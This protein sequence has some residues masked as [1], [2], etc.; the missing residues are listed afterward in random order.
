MSLHLESFLKNVNWHVN[1][2]DSWDGTLIKV[3]INPFQHLCQ[4]KI[5]QTMMRDKK[6]W[7]P[8]G[9]LTKFLHSFSAVI[10]LFLRQ[11]KQLPVIQEKISLVSWFELNSCSGNIVP[12]FFHLAIV[13]SFYGFHS[14]N[15]YKIGLL[16]IPTLFAV[17]YY[18]KQAALF[19]NG[20]NMD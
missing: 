18:A 17:A 7:P 5:S 13:L 12:I 8:A 20:W 14:G 2:E 1:P 11:P 6:N 16:D 3:L 15:P 10:S 19:L 4:N 9:F